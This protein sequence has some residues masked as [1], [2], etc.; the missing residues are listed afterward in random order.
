MPRGRPSKLTP[1]RQKKLVDA[2][3]AGNYYE[4]ACTYAGIDYTTFRLWMQKGEAREAKKYSDF[5]EAITRAEAEAESRAVALWQKAMPEDWR[6]A[7]MFLERR[8]PDRWGKQD[9]LKTE[10]SGT[11]NWVAL[12]QAAQ[13]DDE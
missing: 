8:H 2:I 1:E 5:F 12:A 11:V 9:K 4:T 6:A 3:R 10:V 13:T 7:Q